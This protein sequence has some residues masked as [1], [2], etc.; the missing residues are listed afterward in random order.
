M[1]ED[2]DART[3]ECLTVVSAALG[4]DMPYFVPAE[5]AHFDPIS[6]GVVLAG[7][8][9]TAYLRG[10]VNQA[11]N[12]AE[13]LGSATF[14]WL[15]RSIRRL[16]SKPQEIS[17]DYIIELKNITKQ[18][19][20]RVEQMPR[21]EV[22]QVSEEVRRIL[23]DELSIVWHVPRSHASRITIVVRDQAIYLSTGETVDL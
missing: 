2:H 7:L 5:T 12:Q 4:R 15:R 19:A 9:L 11:E 14:M 17:K 20:T 3:G 1:T 18:S 10:F 23:E 22:A 21:T 16:F 8:M 13:Y 6:V